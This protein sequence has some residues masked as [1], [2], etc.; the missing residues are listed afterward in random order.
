ML[1]V[2][3]ST[4]THTGLEKKKGDG[5]KGM[6]K[7]NPQFHYFGRGIREAPRKSNSVIQPRLAWEKREIEREKRNGTNNNL[8]T[9]YL[10]GLS[11]VN[12]VHC[13][14]G[15]KG[16]KKNTKRENSGQVDS[17]WQRK[18]LFC[19]SLFQITDEIRCFSLLFN[20]F[21]QAFVKQFVTCLRGNFSLSAFVLFFVF[22]F[23]R[24]GRCFGIRF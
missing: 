3:L 8:I 13:R 2:S 15:R 9:C 16:N 24:P 20:L 5:Q 4:P 10:V 19:R 17:L 23:P 11:T 22:T 6:G 1:L 21:I 12:C 14:T 7:I 18:G